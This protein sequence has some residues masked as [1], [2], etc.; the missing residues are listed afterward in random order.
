MR[1]SDEELWNPLDSAYLVWVTTSTRWERQERTCLFDL[2]DVCV[3]PIDDVLLQ[4]SNG[5]VRLTEASEFDV[6]LEPEVE[7]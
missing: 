4:V 3:M 6:F 7:F 1:V 5:F 2:L